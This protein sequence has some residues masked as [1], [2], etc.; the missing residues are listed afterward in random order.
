[1]SLQ[2]IIGSSGAGKSY[3]AYERVIQESLMHPQ[4]NYYVIVPEQFTMQTQKTLVEMHP[5]KGILNIDILSFERLAYRVF[6]ETGGDNRK[7]LEDT[8]K[9]MVLQKMVQQHKKELPYLGSQMNKPG[10]LDEVKSLL[11]EFMQYDIREEDLEEMKEQAKEQGLLEMKLQDVSVLYEAFSGFLKDR[12]MTGEE[13]MD[14]LLKVLPFSRKL[15]GAAPTNPALL[16]PVHFF[17]SCPTPFPDGSLRILYVYFRIFRRICQ[18]PEEDITNFL[19][20]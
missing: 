11:S 9:S 19:P 10:Y 1:M 12:Y 16:F 15:K 8:G 18:S 5:G 20:N 7:I 4:R 3:F 13:V 6:E 14:V 17:M 2:F